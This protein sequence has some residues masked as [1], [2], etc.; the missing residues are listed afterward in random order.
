MT[1]PGL[2]AAL[3][4]PLV[5]AYRRGG[6][7]GG[8]GGALADAVT[9]QFALQYAFSSEHVAS[10]VLRDASA[11]LRPGGVFF[12]VAPDADAILRALGEGESFTLTLSLT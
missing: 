4:E 8:G 12:G 1:E 2:F 11:M 9:V 7:G 3:A 6:G 10:S 5:A